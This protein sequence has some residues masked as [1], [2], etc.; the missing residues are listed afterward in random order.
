MSVSAGINEWACT[1]AC[2][3]SADE[4]GGGQARMNEK[5]H[6]ISSGRVF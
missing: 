2:Q 6:S 1:Q 3:T 5:E 4:Q